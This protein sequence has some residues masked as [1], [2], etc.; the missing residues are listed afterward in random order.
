[1]IMGMEIY[2]IDNSS[3]CEK[4]HIFDFDYLSR[5]L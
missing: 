1:M 5:S 4:K 2:R 3:N